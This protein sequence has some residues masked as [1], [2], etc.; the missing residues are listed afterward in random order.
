MSVG[1]MGVKM[2]ACVRRSIAVVWTNLKANP[3]T[4]N[5]SLALLSLV[6]Y[7]SWLTFSDKICLTQYEGTFPIEKPCLPRGMAVIDS[8]K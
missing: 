5:C 1:M 3:H 7:V 2:S 8:V 4:L 6:I